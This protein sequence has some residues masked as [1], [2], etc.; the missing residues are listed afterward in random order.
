MAVPQIIRVRVGARLRFARNAMRV[1]LQDV[2]NAC[3]VTRQAVSLWE[4][5]KTMP[6]DEMLGRLAEYLGVSR[7]WLLTGDQPEQVE[8]SGSAP[9]ANDRSSPARR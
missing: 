6:N 8:P 5:G 9:K 3:D 1:A 7:H 4:T 2:A